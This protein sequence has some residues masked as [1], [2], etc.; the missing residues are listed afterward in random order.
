MIQQILHIVFALILFSLTDV[1]NIVVPP[2][3]SDQSELLENRRLNSEFPIGIADLNDDGLDDIIR[4]DAGRFLTFELQKPG[5]K[6]MELPFGA[7]SAEEQWQVCVADVDK[8]G[9]KD[10]LISG[11]NEGINLLMNNELN[12]DLVHFPD[13]FFSQGANFS[14]IDNDGFIDAFICNDTG[15]NRILMNNGLGELIFDNYFINPNTIPASDNSGNYSSVWTDFDNDDDLDLYISKCIS[16][17]NTTEEDPRRINRLMVNDG[18]NNYTENAAEFGL[19]IGAQ[20]WVSEFQDI[21][22]DGDLDCF[23][24]NHYSPSQLLLNDGTG[25]YTDV[26]AT[27]NIDLSIFPL[28]AVMKDFNNDTYV[29]LMVTSNTGFEYFQN[30]GDGTFEK[31]EE[32][33]EDFEMNTLAIGDLNNDGSLDLYSGSANPATKDKLMLNDGVEAGFFKIEL[34]GVESNP[35]GIG[36][37]L[38]I[39]GDWGVQVREVRSGESYGVMHSLIQH[40][41]LGEATSIDSLIVKWPSGIKDSYYDLQG[42]QTVRVIEGDC[43]YPGR[44]ILVNSPTVFCTGD[45]VELTAPLGINYAWSNGS[46][47]RTIIV[48]E[49]GNYSVEVEN[50]LSCKTTTVPISVVVDPIEIPE[51]FAEGPLTFCEGEVLTLTSSEAESYAWS[52]GENT[53]TIFVRE[54]GAYWVRVPGLCNDFTSEEIIAEELPSPDSPTNISNDTLT[55]SGTATLSVEGENPV[56]FDEPFGT[57]A[58]FEGNTYETPLLMGPTNY[59]VENQ[60]IHEDLTC[61]SQRV[62]A[63][64][65]FEDA[66]SI[67]EKHETFF[68][69]FPNPN[70]GLFMIES[71]LN[72]GSISIFNSEGQL[73]QQI[74]NTQPII[75]LDLTHFPKGIYIVKLENENFRSF[76]KV[77]IQ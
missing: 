32:L 64:V 4:L 1:N 2:S 76:K 40:F 19:K 73:L 18:N 48:T 61:S 43:I 71:T 22:N 44:N 13:T 55:E 60:I 68:E 62:I 65:I 75:A 38:F 41:G 77:I 56:W 35:D 14:D 69:L 5:A 52:T 26:T 6:F 45:Y 34:K 67:K 58:I 42:N 53:Q 36:T 46:S 20:S 17:P 15:T 57:E 59:F 29:D 23:V 70:F 25:H 51:I 8:N 74:K 63:R 37:K 21:D 11:Y 30:L 33:F 28:Q 9:W 3:F 49:E 7:L 12:F 39:Y 27:S 31:I 72:D 10:V 47:E 16:V 66:T 50:A 24:A 54:S